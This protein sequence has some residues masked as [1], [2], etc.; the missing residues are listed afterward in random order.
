MPVAAKFSEQF[1]DKFGHEATDEL[2]DYLNTVDRTYRSELERQNDA[3]WARFEARLD[4]RFAEFESRFLALEGR[5]ESR[6]L[7]LEGRMDRLEAKMEQR[8]AEMKTEMLKWMFLFWL[9]TI[10]I[11]LALQKL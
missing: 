11:V 3:N 7:A 5:V 2:V 4:Q 1:Y 6:F 10:G 8:F 9:G